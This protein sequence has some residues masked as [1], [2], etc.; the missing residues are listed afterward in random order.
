M[1]KSVSLPI[2]VTVTDRASMERKLDEAV[3][4]AKSQAIHERRQGVLVTRH[5]HSTF[6]ISLTDMVPFGLTR[7]ADQRS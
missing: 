2:T 3:T 5:D 7:E 6:T 4:F 1:T